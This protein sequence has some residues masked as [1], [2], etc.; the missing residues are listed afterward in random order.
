MTRIIDLRVARVEPTLDGA[1]RRTRHLLE[2]NELADGVNG[3]ITGSVRDGRDCIVTPSL[4][5]HSHSLTALSLS[6]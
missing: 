6:L 3:K 4:I 1:W 2:K 5:A